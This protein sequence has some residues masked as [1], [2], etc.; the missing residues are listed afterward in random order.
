MSQ[1]FATLA[2]ILVA[3]V[4][5]AGAWWFLSLDDDADCALERLDSSLSGER[6]PDC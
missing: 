5:V 6:D 3:V 2:A 4:L 1:F